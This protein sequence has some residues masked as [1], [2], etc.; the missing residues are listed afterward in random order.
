MAKKAKKVAE[1]EEKIIRLVGNDK[2][3]IVYGFYGDID[4]A[5]QE[6]ALRAELARAKDELVV[7]QNATDDKDHAATDAAH[8][9]D[10]GNATYKALAA[11]AAVSLSMAAGAAG[12][13]AAYSGA[14]AVPV[15]GAALGGSGASGASGGSGASGAGLP[16]LSVSAEPAGHVAPVAHAPDTWARR[17]LR[18]LRWFTGTPDPIDAIDLT[19]TPAEYD[20]EY[21]AQTETMRKTGVDIL[22]DSS[23]SASRAQGVANIVLADIREGGETELID[24]LVLG[25][26]ADT[27]NEQL[28]TAALAELETLRS[29][30]PSGQYL[31]AKLIIGSVRK[32]AGAW[33]EQLSKAIGVLYP[34][35]GG[36]A[37]SRDLLLATYG[38]TRPDA[39]NMN[40]AGLSILGTSPISTI[41]PSRTDVADALIRLFRDRVASDAADAAMDLANG[42]EWMASRDTMGKGVTSL[43]LA[44]MMGSA[45]ATARIREGPRS[46]GPE[47]YT[48]TS[49]IYPPAVKWL[50]EVKQERALT[51]QEYEQVRFIL[52]AG[53]GDPPWKDRVVDAIGVVSM[54]S[55][56]A[57]GAVGAVG[58][59][60]FENA[61]ATYPRTREGGKRLFAL[62]KFVNRGNGEMRHGLFEAAAQRDHT[63]ARSAGRELMS[64][65]PPWPMSSGLSRMP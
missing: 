25:D 7:L 6:R 59:D 53:N 46:W 10:S 1:L 19:P 31:E 2:P 45:D 37:P 60:V 34:K 22:S 20:K 52:E 23:R 61:L 41:S 64:A 29:R 27:D 5:D 36:E 32:G 26:G 40:A 54:L 51:N 18:R 55:S 14:V 35:G 12:A 24:K 58:R 38:N 15:G 17:G 65:R 39:E 11:A 30:V 28:K 43:V 62:E 21:E 9:A 33:N 16:D 63:A 3:N 8:R 57:V 48:Y 13:A 42:Y 49:S 47:G 56:G 50:D 44:S 4:R